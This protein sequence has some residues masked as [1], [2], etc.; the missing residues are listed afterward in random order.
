MSQSSAKKQ[1]IIKYVVDLYN[2][3]YNKY[4]KIN[5][6]IIIITI[7]IVFIIQ[8]DMPKLI[9]IIYKGI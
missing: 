1:N 2:Q 3:K 5:Y 9:S 6:K 8:Y 4:K 7:Y